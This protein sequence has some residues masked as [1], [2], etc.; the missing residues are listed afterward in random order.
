MPKKRIFVVDDNPTV[1]SM[2]RQ[3]FESEANYVMVGEA[4]NG[5]DAIAKAVFVKPDLIVLDL[6]MPVMSGLDAAPYLR[7]VLPETRLLLFTVHNGLEV[8]RLARAAGIQAVVS[9]DKGALE[10][11]PRSKALLAS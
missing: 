1:R 10:L 7:T 8:E 11:V 9:K 3:L 5:R 4:E 2:V 6:S